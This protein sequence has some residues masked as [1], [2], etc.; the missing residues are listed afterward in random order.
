MKT[1]DP[2]GRGMD[3]VCQS[4]FL[5]IMY[6]KHR[7]SNA[8]D[9]GVDLDPAQKSGADDS[10]RD[11]VETTE[12]LKDALQDWGDRGCSLTSIRGGTSL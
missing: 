4:L 11:L 1:L 10:I 3:I 7:A 12:Q 6:L 5:R 2:K 8:V 9:G